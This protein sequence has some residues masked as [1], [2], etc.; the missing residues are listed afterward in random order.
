MGE[1]VEFPHAGIALAVPQG[2]QMQT[3][4]DSID[5][6]RAEAFQDN[7]P[8]QAVTLSAEPVAQVAPTAEM[9][10]DARIASQANSLTIRNLQ[11]LNTATM[12]VAD[13]DGAARLLSY[14]LRGEETVAAT[15]YFVRELAQ[16]K[17]RMCYILTVVA[18]A[19]RKSDVLPTLGEVVKTV[20]LIAMRHPAELPVNQLGPA[21]R[22]PQGRCSIRLPLGWY[23]PPGPGGLSMAQTDYLLGGPPTV[24]AH[25]V[26]EAVDAASVQQRMDQCVEAARKAAAD[27][28]LQRRLLSRKNAELAGREACQIVF[29]QSPNTQPAS[30]PQTSQAA[31]SATQPGAVATPPSVVIV[32]RSLCLPGAEGKKA[33]NFSL[34]LVAQG[35]APEA[36]EAMMDKIAEGFQ[37]LGPASTTAPATSSAPAGPLPPPGAAPQETPATPLPG[38]Q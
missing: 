36:S 6:M 10:A 31:E 35:A 26:V 13:L 23:A 9:L 38:V 24:S 15:L 19:S 3:V 37:L 18:P 2:H 33:E 8:V 12:K 34:V 30:A 5:V 32:Q 27:R 21:M 22:D 25:V 28:N 16:P 17:M 11:V 14:T 20:R 1:A 7:Q 29:Q 4:S